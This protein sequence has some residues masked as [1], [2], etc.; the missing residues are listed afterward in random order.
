M[1]AQTLKKP[2]QLST[3]LIHYEIALKLTKQNNDCIWKPRS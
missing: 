2:V 3:L 1:S